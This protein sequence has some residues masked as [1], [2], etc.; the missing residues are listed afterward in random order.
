MKR[1]LII[2]S[3][4]IPCASAQGG[5]E[6][7]GYVAFII[8]V[9][10]F[11]YSYR[12]TSMKNDLE[13]RIVR[14]K[15]ALNKLQAEVRTARKELEKIR[16][17][18]LGPADQISNEIRRT[19]EAVGMKMKPDGLKEEFWDRLG[20]MREV[21]PEKTELDGLLE[22]KGEIQSMIDMAKE[23]YHTR[24]I[25]QQTFCNITEGYQ[26]RLIEVEAKIKKMRGG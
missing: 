23:K 2:L 5:L 22:E 11:L 17:D 26:K 21:K 8:G 15:A 24:T 18:A 10:A 19:E 3:T 6:S 20:Q 12:L 9:L 25:D 16:R 1:K 13:A 4:I 7:L 14:E